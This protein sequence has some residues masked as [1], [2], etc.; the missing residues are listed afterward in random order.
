MSE[1]LHQNSKGIIMVWED[2]KKRSRVRV[3]SVRD[4]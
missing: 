3:F 2:L 1:L 4:G